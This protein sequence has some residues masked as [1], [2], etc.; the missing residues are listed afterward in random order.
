MIAAAAWVMLLAA[1][2]DRAALLMTFILPPLLFIVFAAIFA[3][4]SGTDLKLKVGIIDAAHTK[5]SARLLHALEE[6][7]NFRYI[8]MESGGADELA[9]FIRRGMADA[10]LLIRGDPGL[11]PDQGPPPLVLVEN[12]SRPL[13]ASIVSG[14]VQRM[15]NEKLPDVALGRI[16]ADVETSGAIGKDERQFLSDAFREEAAGRAGQKFSFADVLERKTAQQEGQSR[17]G[18]VLY[19]A[20]AV[21]SVFLLFAAVHGSLTLLDEFNNGI[22]DRLA[23]SRGSFTSLIIG[24]FCFLTS[25]GFVQVSL[26]YL[27]AYLLYGASFDPNRIAAWTLTCFLAS[28][29]AT[30]LALLLCA[31]CRSRKQAETFT[32]F[33][34]LLISAIGGSMIPRYLM[35]P[36]LQELGWFTPNAW[37]IRAFELAVQPAAGLRE[38]SLPLGILAALAFLGLA[39]AAWISARRAAY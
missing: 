23:I 10:G 26:V 14:Q 35:P 15:L 4:A 27:F 36:W 3:G 33:A 17:N 9:D 8:A 28:A 20:G 29:A 1:L 6:D 22:A 12:P 34:V 38:L 37:I 11:R 39:G 32:T 31:L 16:L 13:A 21:V 30:A 7:R 5:D 24:K 25:Q 2:R 19:Y 18:N